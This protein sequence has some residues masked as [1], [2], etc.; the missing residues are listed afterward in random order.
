MLA[1]SLLDGL[2]RRLKILKQQTFEKHAL[3]YFFCV[4]NDEKRS[5]TAGV[6]RPLLKK[7]AKV[8]MLDDYSGA[9]A[10]HMAVHNGHNDAAVLLL[11][12][13]ADP[14][15]RETKL[16]TSP[17][18]LAPTKRDSQDLFKLLLQRPADPNVKDLIGRTALF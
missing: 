17:L 5:H 16:D 3:A 1:I 2:D 6:V 14:N 7:V 18:F 8:N 13:G 11:E 12:N 15:V 10:L 4:H 9:T